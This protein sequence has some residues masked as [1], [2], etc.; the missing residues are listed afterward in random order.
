[1]LLIKQTKNNNPSKKQ[2]QK[3]NSNKL[4]L[5][6][7]CYT[8]RSVPYLAVIRAASA[9]SAAD[10]NKYKDPHVDNIQRVTEPHSSKWD[11]S[12]LNRSPHSSGH[13]TGVEAEDVRGS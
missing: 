12:P 1:M 2:K 7:F 5:L 6:T 3:Q 13:S 4:L 8:H 9:S 10:G 11:V